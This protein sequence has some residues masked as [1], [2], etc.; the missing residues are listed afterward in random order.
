MNFVAYVFS[1][2]QNYFYI[3]RESQTTRNVLWSCASVCLSTA[4]WLHYYTDKDVTWWS[5]R[6]CPQLCT[7]GRICNRCT[8]CVA[9]ATLRKCV[10]EPSGNPSDP[11]HAAR[12]TH[13]CGEDSPHRKINAPAACAVPFRPY[14]GAVVTRTRNVSEYTLVLALCLVV[15]D[16]RA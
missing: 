1:L 6:G 7:V 2:M 10:A 9:M 4:A 13:A 16:G 12:T 11:Q 8:G 14:C 15:V 5:G 3:S